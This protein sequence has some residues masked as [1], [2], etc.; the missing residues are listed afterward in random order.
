MTADAR[1]STSGVNSGCPT[2]QPQAPIIGIADEEL[3]ILGGAARTLNF[4]TKSATNGTSAHSLATSPTRARNGLFAVDSSN[5]SVF[6]PAAG[7]R[8]PVNE[9]VLDAPPYGPIHFMQAIDTNPSVEGSRG[10][11][12]GRNTS[13]RNDHRNN[14]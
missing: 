8:Q 3:Q 10:R 2:S 4:T 7:P 12:N 11:G 14:R 1:T 13:H 6:C 5:Q 9:G